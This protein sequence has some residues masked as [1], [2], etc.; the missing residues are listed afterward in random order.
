[1]D[2]RAGFLIPPPT[3]TGRHEIRVPGDPYAVEDPSGLAWVK[4]TIAVAGP[5]LVHY[6]NGRNHPFHYDFV[7]SSL[8]PYVGI[9][10]ADFDAKS[11][12]ADGQELVLGVVLYR[13]ASNGQVAEVAIQL[14]RGDPYDVAEI[15]QWFETIRQSVLLGA[16]DEPPP[17]VYVPTFEQEPSA[18]AN[19]DA[20]AALGVR[21]VP[22][23]TWLADGTGSS[24]AGGW[25]LGELV[26]VA[27]GEVDAAYASGELG[28]DDV[29]L[30]D[31]VPA[32][33]P[34]VAGILS[35][36]PATPSAHV[37]I[38]AR[39]WRIPFAFVAEPALQQQALALVGGQVLVRS[40]DPRV[41]DIRAPD[42]ALWDASTLPAGLADALVE[43]RTVAPL[44]IT[45]KQ[46]YGGLSASVDGLTPADIRFFG[47]KASGYGVL[48]DAIPDAS[49]P[50]VAFSFDLWDAFLAQEVAPGTTLSD[51]IAARLAPFDSY[52]P[53][54]AVLDAALSA[55]RDRIEDEAV[56]GKSERDAI[57]A[58]LGG[59]DPSRRIR[60]RSSTNVEDGEAFTG[61]G[62]Y[63]SVSGCLAD[64]TDGDAVGPSLCDA[65]RANE[66]GVFRAIKRVYASFYNRNAF[67]ERLRYGVDESTVGMAVLAHH[68]FP[69]ET[70]LANGVA[71]LE[72]PVGSRRTSQI[73]S[74][75]GAA[76]VTNPSDGALPEIAEVQSF[77]FAIPPIVE[78]QQG[79]QLLQVGATVLEDGE[80]A[81]L[82]GLLLDAHDAWVLHA[83]LAG[84]SLDFEWKKIEGDEGLVVKQ[85]RWLPADDAAP[86]APFLVE[87]AAERCGQTS[88]R[89]LVCL[90]LGA[91]AERLD[92]DGVTSELYDHVTVEWTYAGVEGSLSASVDALPAFA[93]DVEE[94]VTGT[95]RVIDSFRLED[96]GAT[97]E[98]STLLPEQATPSAPGTVLA[99]DELRLLLH[100][101]HDE[102]W[103][104]IGLPDGLR[105]EA[106]GEVP[107]GWSPWPRTSD[108]QIIG[109]PN[110]CEAPTRDGLSS[111]TYRGA[112]GLEIEQWYSVSI[113]PLGSIATKA[114]TVHIA[115]VRIRGLTDRELVL[116]SPYAK[117]AHEHHHGGW[118]GTWMNPLLDP[119]VPDEDKHQWREAGLELLYAFQPMASYVPIGGDRVWDE[120][121]VWTFGDGETWEHVPAVMVPEP[122]APWAALLALAGLA[123]W[124]RAAQNRPSCTSFSPSTTS[125]A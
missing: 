93:H 52:P 28:P 41:D 125:D 67:L 82:H 87:P 59:F 31:A 89:M 112:D 54:I 33:V 12:H 43:L 110:H 23:G 29:L 45:G 30:L 6:Q 68:S 65:T 55:I 85:I 38:L 69:D 113:P 49:R 124:R 27:P 70:E 9:S 115:E 120:G 17:A 117:G 104:G 86:V 7:T 14:V 15:A 10:P 107:F 83:P 105:F 101:A 119:C 90:S 91:S 37:A 77:T 103:P 4:L 75:P 80:Y 2:A 76:S 72:R 25:A 13:R 56:F 19:A 20:L 32:E 58:A 96:L 78:I 62:L 5:D 8:E 94:G 61:A 99:L 36:A 47:G 34:R 84:R 11:F 121:L 95:P 51:D 102:A 114:F 44:A 108:R 63:D 42:F 1:M 40:P 123:R 16:A 18:L 71:V 35:L 46:T 73:V 97:I 64:D 3:D 116:R 118:F 66:R 60:F 22:A 50:A 98:L 88:P 92:V 122:V 39:D 57:L 48:R 100:V 81:T 109:G 106:P 24:Y 79:A 53:D 21:V 74:Q 26:H 111:Q